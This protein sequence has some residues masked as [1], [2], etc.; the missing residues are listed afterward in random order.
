WKIAGALARDVDGAG[1]G[2]HAQVVAAHLPC[3]E[4]PWPGNAAAQIEY[5]D[6]RRNPRL[7]REVLN[8]SGAHKALLLDEFAGGVRR[9]TGPV[10]G[11]DERSALVL[12]YHRRSPTRLPAGRMPARGREVLASRQRPRWHGA[13]AGSSRR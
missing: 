6:P 4:A 12:L 8:L 9:D 1:A 7:T 2:V 5:R 11:P 10:E 13:N 3:D